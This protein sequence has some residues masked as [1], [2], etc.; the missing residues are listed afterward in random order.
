MTNSH[1]SRPKTLLIQEAARLMGVSRRTV[2]YR[3][4]DGRLD[5]IRTRCGSRRIVV[6]S[7][8]LLKQ[9]GIRKN[10]ACLKQSHL[11][12]EPHTFKV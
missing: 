12:A 4:R 11:E 2:Y 8:D 6:H 10:A 9:E 5:S 1:E 7:I 3:I